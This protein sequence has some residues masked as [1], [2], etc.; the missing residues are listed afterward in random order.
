MPDRVQLG[1]PIFELGGSRL[2]RS[3]DWGSRRR[4]RFH[5]RSRFHRRGCFH[6]RGRF[7]RRS[8]FHW[9][10]CSDGWGQIQVERMFRRWRRRRHRGRQSQAGPGSVQQKP[11]AGVAWVRLGQAFEDLLGLLE[12]LFGQ[13]HLAHGL[14]DHAIVLRLGRSPFDG[15]SRRSSRYSRA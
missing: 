5:W 9:R 10:G 3:S 11:V 6:W 14:Q 4:G 15:F 12:H 1:A 13:A 2:R 8:C 7:H